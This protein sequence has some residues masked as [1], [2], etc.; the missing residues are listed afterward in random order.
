MSTVALETYFGESAKSCKKTCSLRS[1]R[2]NFI[3]HVQSSKKG[4]LN[5]DST[6]LKTSPG[7]V[8]AQ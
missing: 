2:L 3:N 5:K 7:T 1:T 8:Q 6:M 4:V